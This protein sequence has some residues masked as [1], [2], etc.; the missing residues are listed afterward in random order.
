MDINKNLGIWMDHSIA[1]LMEFS[2]T[3]K[4]NTIESALTHNKKVDALHRSESLMHNKE[5]Q[6]HEAYYKEIADEILKYDHVLLF[7]PTNAKTELHNY[8]KRD[9]HF[10][11]IKIDIESADKMIDNEQFAHVRKHFESLYGI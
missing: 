5:Q 2:D 1:N 7:G 9:L 11:D 3:I 10:R 6:L 4:C 8:L